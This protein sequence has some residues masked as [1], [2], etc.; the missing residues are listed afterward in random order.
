MRKIALTFAAFAALGVALPAVS[1]P[2]SARDIVVIKKHRDH[3]WRHHGW[4]RGHH[5]GWSNH[6]H[7]RSHS[8]GH[9]HGATIVVR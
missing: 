9:R 4:H 1:S 3:G 2:A 6:H 8:H 7:W 5:Y